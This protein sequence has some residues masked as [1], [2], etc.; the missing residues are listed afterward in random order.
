MCVMTKDYLPCREESTIPS[1]SRRSDM[2]INFNAENLYISSIISIQIMWVSP[3][4][5]SYRNW[6]ETRKPAE[7]R[8]R[9]AKI[10]KKHL[11][12]RT[13]PSMRPRWRFVELVRIFFSKRISEMWK[14]VWLKKCNKIE[15]LHFS[16]WRF[17]FKKGKVANWEKKKCYTEESA[18]SGRPFT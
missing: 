16:S 4:S 3:V 2:T 18:D 1:S 8:V 9:P 14:Y 5:G 6:P 15:L 7:N 11:N 10:A 12:F 17:T 13:K